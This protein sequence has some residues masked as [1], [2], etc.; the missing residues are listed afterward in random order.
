MGVEWS[1]TALLQA[2]STRSAA[3]TGLAARRVHRG[4][5][6]ALDNIGVGVDRGASHGRGAHH[7][8]CPRFHRSGRRSCLALK[9][10]D[11]ATTNADHGQ[12]DHHND[13]YGGGFIVVLVSV[14]IAFVHHSLDFG[15]RAAEMLGRRD[16]NPGL[17]GLLYGR[18][19]LGCTGVFVRTGVCTAE[20]NATVGITRSAE[21]GMAGSSCMNMGLSMAPLDRIASVRVVSM[22]VIVPTGSPT[23]SKVS[24]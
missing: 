16:G 3:L 9:V 12:R 14:G 20:V 22:I 23:S 8:G 6:L 21:R 17:L 19:R 4:G 15:F 7:R 10:K 18:V 13:D 24:L 2:E 1:Q 11:R 5:G